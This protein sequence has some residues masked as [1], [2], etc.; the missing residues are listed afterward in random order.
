MICRVLA[1]VLGGVALCVAPAAGAWDAAGMGALG[2]G[3]ADDTAAFQNALDSAGEAGGGVVHVPAG[4]YRINGSLR[5]PAGV[6]LEGTFRVPPTCSYGKGPE[7]VGSVLH[8]YAGRGSREGEPFIRLAGNTATLAGFIITYPEWKQE[9]V[10][11]V[12]YPPAVAAEHVEDVGVLDCCIVN[13][14]EALFFQNSARF[15]VRNVFGYPSVRGLYIDAC[16]DISRVENCHFW[17][18]GVSYRHDD[19]FCK[20]VNTNGVAFEF[21]RTDWQYVT[22]TFCFGYGVGYR[23]SKSESGACNG[24]FVGIGAD[25][26]RRPVLVMDAQPP[27]LLITNGEFVG[28][29]GSEDSV[30]IEVARTAGAGKVSL[31]N[32]SFWGPI[33]RCIWQRSPRTQLTVMG[34][35]FCSWDNAYR[36]SPAIQLDAGKAI[37]QGNTFGDGDTHVLVGRDVESAVLVG[38][39]AGGG[40]VCENQA[41]DRTQL[42]ANEPRGVK[43]PGKSK[44]HYVVDVGS[45]GDRPYAKEWHG[46]EKAAEWPEGE[47]TKR[48]SQAKSILK[49]PIEPGKPY[50]ITL[51]AHVPPHA[52]S[53]GNGLYVGDTCVLPFPGKEGL[54]AIAGTLPVSREDTIVLRLQVKG[55]CPKD[56]IQ[57]SNDDRTLGI[58]VRSVT[59]KSKRAPHTP[60]NANTGEWD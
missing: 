32:C 25:S 8:A 14:S 29:W 17:P 58:A 36:G 28:R 16:Y 37:I 56:V 24:S 9:D 18:F 6:T 4:T 48:W 49:L 15:I 42:L 26:C 20:W 12:P 50:T 39:Q 1:V 2:D 59:M 43:W 11:P 3:Q 46:Q 34:T 21:A 19:P 41:G 47:G 22:H 44:R 55:W 30:G 40:F 31:S 7:M 10:P 53:P 13:A 45:D 38:N 51:E 60:Y 33:D 23:F 5:I 35:N 52:M 27:G 57:G 54:V